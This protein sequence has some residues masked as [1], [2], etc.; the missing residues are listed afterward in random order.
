[1]NLIR[2]SVFL[3]TITSLSSIWGGLF[4]QTVNSGNSVF[5]FDNSAKAVKSVE[6]A[7]NSSADEMILG[8][9]IDKTSR[10]LIVQGVKSGNHTYHGAIYLPSSILDKYAGDK[11]SA[12]DFGISKKRGSRADVFVCTDIDYI[13]ETQKATASTRSYKE[14][15]NRVSL[16]LPYKIVKG[17]DLYVGYI[18]NTTDEDLDFLLF[19][20]SSF[21]FTGRNFYGH[22]N[23]WYDNLTGIN[24]NLCIRAVITG[25]NVPNNDISFIRVTSANGGNVVEQNKPYSYS[26]YVI[27][28]GKTPVTSLGI[29][30]SAKGV[31]S[32]EVDVDGYN[33]PNGIPTKIDFD[34]VSVPSDGNITA[35][36][37]VTKVN[38]EKDPDLTDNT[39]SM[40]LYAIK[41]GG[42]SQPHTV[43]V[44]DFTSEGY[45]NAELS[46]KTTKTSFEAV[47]ETSLI[48]VRH[49]VNW[50]GVKDP[51]RLTE[52]GEYL[53]LFGSSEPFL[54]ALAVD[55]NIF[56]QLSEETAGPG[57]AY[58]MP[59]VETAGQLADAS[60]S[61]PTFITLKA[62]TKR[63][64][65]KLAVTVDATTESSE[66]PNQSDLRLTTWLVEDSIK[67]TKQ[68][69]SEDYVHNGVIRKVLSGNAWGDRVE[70]KDYAFQ[71][72]Y[73]V[74]FDD[75]WNPKNLSVVAFVSNQ[76]KEVTKRSIFNSCQ[77][78]CK[79]E[80][81]GIE[82]VNT[83]KADMSIVG[84]KLYLGEG[85][86]LLGIYDM[87]GRAYSNGS[88]NAGMYIVK[89]TDGKTVYTKKIRINK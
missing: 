28:N 8:Y 55:R 69:G 76:G 13:K 60:A 72:T 87:A 35:N 48:W 51:Y 52:D 27:N 79:D 82:Q 81:S 80:V 67:T 20:D 16:N 38:G 14:G 64:G 45:E 36:F 40:Y 23:N 78:F 73:E 18:I 63:D 50:N 88:L 70:I 33:I 29:S 57:P 30:A 41:E 9:C 44:E 75:S 84:G 26:G 47:P 85:C 68:A 31:T 15:W 49:H 66:M 11:I 86:S 12:I 65:K 5:S 61:V 71:K 2:K 89:A 39:A 22:D 46:E 56:P 32:K 43:L 6:K 74:E 34:G 54:P 62:S 59:W 3:F 83:G 19:D 25:D 77:F 42:K 4:A 21:G 58:Y 37:S 17:Q 53:K 10:G 7:D 1:M 24:K